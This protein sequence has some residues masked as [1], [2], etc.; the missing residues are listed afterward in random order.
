MRWVVLFAFV[1][2][3]GG[4]I[5]EP[6]TGG[7]DAGTDRDS[8][9]SSDVDTDSGTEVE[10]DTDTP[11]SNVNY[12][13]PGPLP[14]TEAEGSLTLTDCALEYTMYTPAG[15]TTAPLVV[16]G[17]GFSRDKSSM[18]DVARHIAGHGLRVVTPSYCFSGFIGT[19]H[20]RN[21]QDAADLSAALAGDANV[22]HVGFSAG[23][24]SAFVAA[25][26]DDA[27]VGV[28]GL[29]MV[30]T[31]GTNIAN[32]A[33][34]SLTIPVYGVVGDSGQ[35]NSNN[36]GVPA[37]ST[38]SMGDAVRVPGATHCDFEGPTG[39]TCTAFCGGENAAQKLTARAMASA[40][41]ASV[42]GVDP[43]ANAW[44]EAGGD[45]YDDLLDAGDIAPL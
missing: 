17:H 37:Y 44:L 43:G 26:D 10:P 6:D 21:G 30:D 2:C 41:A 28:F 12:E 4:G 25:A 27:A 13:A 5:L 36:N 16:L 8:D 42:T 33:A 1:G 23:G 11:V 34:Q 24:A 38:A 45:A 22:V 15:G 18:V 14:L 35:C 7:L 31:D 32:D 9:T 29:D 3:D 20:A 19:D 39:F 40:F